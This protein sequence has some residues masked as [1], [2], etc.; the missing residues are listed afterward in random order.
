M[1]RVSGSGGRASVKSSELR[2]GEQ[3]RLTKDGRYE[4]VLFRWELR[5]HRH[6]WSQPLKGRTDSSQLPFL[7][8]GAVSARVPWWN[9]L[10][11]EALEELLDDLLQ[12]GVG[13]GK[14]NAKPSFLSAH[15]PQPHNLARHSHHGLPGKGHLE[16]EAGA[17][18]VG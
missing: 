9:S 2:D 4:Q 10:G 13:L 17:E 14:L 3:L 18:G 11:G 6:P 16:G 7:K 5:N 1:S 15:L 8:P 12:V